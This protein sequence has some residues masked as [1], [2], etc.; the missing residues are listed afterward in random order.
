MKKIFIGILLI[1]FGSNLF[2]GDT[3]LDPS[4]LSL[5]V[6]EVWL[7]ISA[8][9]DKDDATQLHEDNN[10]SY[11]NMLVSPTIGEGELAKGKYKCVIMKVSDLIK[12]KPAEGGS[13]SGGCDDE[14]TYTLDVC[15]TGDSTVDLDGTETDCGVAGTDDA[16]YLYLS[17]AVDG[18]ENQ[19]AFHPPTSTSNETEAGLQLENALVIKNS[20]SVANFVVDASGQV[21]DTS[22][23]GCNTAL[24]Q[25]CEMNAP[26][27]RFEK[28][29]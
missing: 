4:S 10:P 3:G 14:T 9:C 21:C 23:D 24:G 20:D 7:S 29:D 16:V 26:T 19:N 11:R 18:S 15:R 17:T 22:V 27:F 8:T 1:S 6:Y 13:T 5:K 12:F 2:A 25:T 28:V